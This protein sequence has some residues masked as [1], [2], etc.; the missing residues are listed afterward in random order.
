MDYTKHYNRLMEKR[1]N[2][3]PS[4]DTYTERHHILPRCC[5]GDDSPENIVTLTAREHFVAHMLLSEMYKEGSEEWISL[6][7][8]FRFMRSNSTGQKRHIGARYFQLKREDFSKAMSLAQGGEKN[9]QFGKCW[10][11]NIALEE[12]KRIYKEEKDIYLSNGWKLGR[13]L[14][15]REDKKNAKIIWEEFTESPHFT[16]RPFS[17]DSEYHREYITKI[18][19]EHLNLGPSQARILKFKITSKKEIEEYLESGHPSIAAFSRSKG[20]GRNTHVTRWKRYVP[21][22]YKETFG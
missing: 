8:A 15:I 9:S 20:Y 7:C 10:V 4:P 13:R 11:F 12:C 21:K 5:G 14:D 6:N 19:R 17:E 16:I 18:F 3:P 2:N 1:K 22:L